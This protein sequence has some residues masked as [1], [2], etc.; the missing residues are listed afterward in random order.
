MNNNEISDIRGKKEF[1]GITFSK[2]KKSDA[3][4]EL[5]T[6]LYQ[7]KIEN[8]CYWAAEF[9]CAGHFL[10]LWDI[11]MLFAG[12]NIHLGNPKLP[13][14]L[15]LIFDNFKDILSNGYINNELKLRNND[16]IRKIFAEIICILSLSKKKNSFDIPK[17]KDD[18]YDVTIISTKLEA[19]TIKYANKIFMKEDPK[20]LFISV[21]EFAWNLSSKVQNPTKAFYWVEWILNFETKCKKKNKN[22]LKANR[23]SMPVEDKFQMDIIWIIWDIILKES[24]KYNKS[25]Q[26]I[27]NSLLN[28]YCIKFAPSCKKKR[29]FLMYN[30]IFLLTEKIDTKIQIYSDEKTI[31]NVK[32]NINNIYKQIKKN[33]IKPQT[34]YLFNNSINKN[35]EKTVDKLD[36][37]NSIASFIPRN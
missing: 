12:K 29:K 34:D 4:K 22:G 1:K 14:Y 21:N 11:I 6:N 2:F 30:A 24:L 18:D 36:K 3:K 5:L 15:N 26:K 35:L 17:M 19:K 13:I 9:I 31:N 28:L 23:R 33:E 10:D 8:A 32:N 16:K 7:S 37:M 25:F 27:I 20:E